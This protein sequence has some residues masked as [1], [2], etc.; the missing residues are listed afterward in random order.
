[1][2]TTNA[3]TPNASA[4]AAT[5]DIQ[6]TLGLSG[7]D[8]IAMLVSDSGL[9]SCEPKW[10]NAS[11]NGCML[12][13]LQPR[14]GWQIVQRAVQWGSDSWA[15]CFGVDCAPPT[16]YAYFA[17]SI[18]NR[19]EVLASPRLR[20]PMDGITTAGAP[21]KVADGEFTVK[22]PTKLVDGSR[23]GQA[24]IAAVLAPEKGTHYSIADQ[25]RVQM[26]S[27][28]M[29]GAGL[30]QV[31]E[32]DGV[33]GYMGRVLPR[34]FDLDSGLGSIF[35]RLA[36]GL[37]VASIA[38]LVVMIATWWSLV[39]ENLFGSGLPYMVKI[40]SFMCWATGAMGLLMLGGSPSVKVVVKKVPKHT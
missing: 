35:A 31:E 30:V 9:A 4:A 38:T 40:V 15:N 27:V 36:A 7:V 33:E 22:R 5:S 2:N 37:S 3:T 16:L 13:A 10:W 34:D 1:M 18:R 26:L 23:G 32:D 17:C 39:R 11:P 8:L 20:S 29:V 19:L 24:F 14:G 25:S 6:S 21:W 12:I 28:L